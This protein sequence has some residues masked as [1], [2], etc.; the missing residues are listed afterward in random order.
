[1]YPDASEQPLGRVIRAVSPLDTQ[2]WNSRVQGAPAATVFHLAEWA[3]VLHTVY[4]FRPFYVTAFE[5][6]A[7]CGLLPAMEVGGLLAPRRG[8]SLPFSDSCEPL[9]GDSSLY[10]ELFGVLRQVARDRGWRSLELRGGRSFLPGQPAARTCRE[11]M[12]DLSAGE[13]ELWRKLKPTARTAV[14]RAQA[15]GVTCRMAVDIEAMRAFYRLHCLTRKRHGVPPQPF[16]FFAEICRCF[17]GRGLG[18][19][20]LAEWQQQPVAACVYLR[21]GRSV[22]YKF[23]ASDERFQHLRAGNLVMWEAI[24]HYA[25]ESCATLSF[26]RTDHEDEGLR[27]YKLTWGAQERLIEY[28]RFDCRTDAF[29]G[30]DGQPTGQWMRGVFRRLPVPLLRLAGSLLYRYAG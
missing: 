23:G 14:R 1:M 9:V 29:I 17:L 21:A 20:L 22:V 27:R 26:G 7:L 10:Q 3:E 5:A 13:A 2:A 25:G 11:H 28:F 15:A 19:V 18:M 6:G 12:L 8:V 4:G 24:R 16:A 30:G